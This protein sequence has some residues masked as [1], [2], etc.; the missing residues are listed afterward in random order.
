MQN[1]STKTIFEEWFEEK[2]IYFG[3]N[4]TQDLLNIDGYKQ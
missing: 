1:E 4:E 3:K 2:V